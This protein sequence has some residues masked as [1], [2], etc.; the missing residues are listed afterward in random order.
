[1]R[2]SEIED[3]ILDMGCTAE[4]MLDENDVVPDGQIISVLRK[5]DN[6]DQ[7]DRDGRTLLMNAACYGRVEIVKYL[8]NHGANV[9]AKD[10]AGLTAL[11][12]A[13]KD[14]N[15]GIITLLLDAGADVNCRNNY[16]NSPIM[17]CNNLTPHNIFAVLLSYGADPM[18]KNNF[19][20][21]ALDVF[22][23]LAL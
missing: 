15:K 17:M 19:G 5:F 11:H 9:N 8:I 12:F 2:I 1:M 21:N 6:L 7:T 16:G 10:N 13:V 3:I 20:N 14:A 4:Y 22:P 18:Q 23:F